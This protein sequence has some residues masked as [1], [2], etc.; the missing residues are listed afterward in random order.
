MHSKGHGCI[1]SR[2]FLN[3]RHQC[4]R[5]KEGRPIK[6]RV[7]CKAAA[8]ANPR[9]SSTAT[10]AVLEDKC[11][12]FMESSANCRRS[13]RVK[14][15]ER[16]RI[17]KAQSAQVNKSDKESNASGKNNNSL[18]SKRARETIAKLKK[19]KEAKEVAAIVC[20]QKS[21]HA[22][23]TEMMLKATSIE[24]AATKKLLLITEKEAEIQQRNES[25][26]SATSE[27]EAINKEIKRSKEVLEE[28]QQELRRK[29]K[30][31]RYYNKL[32]NNGYYRIE[33]LTRLLS[34]P[35]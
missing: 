1:V 29:K 27:L 9:I 32:S 35:V 7:V 3:D 13:S 34:L 26:R 15:K 30:L 4:T 17:I 25:I 10:L 33:S 16:E 20:A 6:V 14:F 8:E 11:N 18:K 19:R 5:F 22:L 24:S 21:E 31:H 12:A 23:A 28:C 2:D